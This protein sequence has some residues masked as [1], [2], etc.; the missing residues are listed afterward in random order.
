MMISH[1]GVVV[2]AHVGTEE[3]GMFLKN[4]D[5]YLNTC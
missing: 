2:N 5:P 3:Q 4:S 1:E